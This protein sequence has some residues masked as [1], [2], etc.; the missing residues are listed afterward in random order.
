MATQN[1]FSPNTKISS[2]Q[3]NANFTALWGSPQGNPYKFSVYTTGSTTGTINTSTVIAFGVKLY[4]TGNNFSANVFTVPVTGYYHFD[5]CVWEIRGTNTGYD[6]TAI[7]VN[8][9]EAL[10]S[11]RLQLGSGANC[12]WICNGSLFLTAGQTVDLRIYSD[13]AAATVQISQNRSYFMGF[14]VSLT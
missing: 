10:E 8:G 5:S 13:G 7:F 2:S 12:S 6:S 1:T 14:L 4:D 11:N 9:V 3:V